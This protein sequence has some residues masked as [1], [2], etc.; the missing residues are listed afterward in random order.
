VSPAD[1]LEG[2]RRPFNPQER[3][4]KEY[5][6]ERYW[7]RFAA[8]YDRDGEY[9]VGRAILEAIVENLMKERLLG[10]VI[11]F[12]CGTGYFTKAIAENATHVLATDLS[13]EMLEVAQT[14]LR[15]FGNITIQKA[16]CRR[17]SFPAETFD[18]AVL[19]NL[20]HVIENRLKCLQETNRI[21]RNRGTLIVVDF[22]GWRMPLLKKMKL[23]IRYLRK[24]GRP[25]RSEQNDLSPEE[26]IHL[27]E[28]AGFMIE[29]V[30][31][32]EDGAN[33]LYLKGEK[34]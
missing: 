6:E 17:S 2:V 22:T 15:E 13:H 28:N 3:F 27:V 25:P 31:L 4:V 8:S 10:Q 32:L 12:G 1:Q 11:E 20:L 18:T 7:S 9:V 14:E 23:V 30:Q 21:L 29:G 5:R 34:R 26:L 24:W 33:A 16:D 19:V